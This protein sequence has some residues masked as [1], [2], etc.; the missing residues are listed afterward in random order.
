MKAKDLAMH[1]PALHLDVSSTSNIAAQL[2][3]SKYEILKLKH[4]DLT[5]KHRPSCRCR[6][7]DLKK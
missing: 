3:T 6:G 1:V 7:T 5:G 4:N 2:K